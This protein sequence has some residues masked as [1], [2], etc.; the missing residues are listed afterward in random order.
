LVYKRKQ[1][2]YGVRGRLK[3]IISLFGDKHAS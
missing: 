2:K 1:V 3:S